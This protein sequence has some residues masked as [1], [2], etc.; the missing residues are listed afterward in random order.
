FFEGGT[1]Y[2][3]PGNLPAFVAAVAGAFGGLDGSPV[4]SEQ[5]TFDLFDNAYGL[6]GLQGTDSTSVPAAY[7]NY[8]LFD[9]DMVYKRSGFTQIT[10]TANFNQEY[11]TFPDD[12]VI[13]EAGFIYC[14]V[15]MES[16][17]GRVLW[18]DFKVT[19]IEHPVVQRNSYYP[20]GLTFNEYQRVTAKP[21]QWKFTGK[22]RITDLDL[23]WD[24]FGARMY[25]PDIGRWGVVDPMAEKYYDYSPYAYAL[26]NPVNFIDPDG[27]Q[28][29][30]PNDDINKALTA[31]G[32]QQGYEVSFNKETQMSTV[33][34]TSATYS[35]D[36]VSTNSNANITLTESVYKIDSDGNLVD[37][38]I[39]TSAVSAS[40]E[41]SIDMFGNVER[42]VSDASISKT[43]HMF[44]TESHDASALDKMAKSDLVLE[45]VSMLLKSPN[46]NALS[47]QD[48]GL[49]FL[50]LYDKF[51]NNKGNIIQ[52]LG[53]LTG[54]ETG[55]VE[56][57]F[58][59]KD[60]TTLMRFQLNQA[61]EANDKFHKLSMS[62]SSFQRQ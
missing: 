55:G 4:P 50:S 8:I 47:M 14:F 7:L 6:I 19:V 35:K 62:R 22:E 3:S 25:M 2:D 24:D 49:P 1:G 44:A 29:I 42:S 45:G 16:A 58:G 52:G 18:D 39:T 11:V 40:F 41:E 10:S 38:T 30:D 26:N 13:P 57:L 12:I 23:N 9:Q 61:A 21:N 34:K 60:N 32:K 33:H 53:A 31:V 51:E 20:F 17:T 28:V 43:D 5:A 48:S 15:S 37:A 36:K 27:M 59:G 56:K 46:R 54:R